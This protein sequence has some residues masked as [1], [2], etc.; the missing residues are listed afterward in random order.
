[1]PV[2]ADWLAVHD[3]KPNV[4]SQTDIL[5]NLSNTVPHILGW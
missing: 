5:N 1:M 2:W 4:P 3:R